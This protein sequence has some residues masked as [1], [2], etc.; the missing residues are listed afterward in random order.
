MTNPNLTPKQRE[1]IKENGPWALVLKG[2]KRTQGKIARIQDCQ[3][4]EDGFWYT[5]DFPKLGRESGFH[6][7]SIEVL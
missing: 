7:S 5:L 2:S 3:E 4:N 1:Q 6:E